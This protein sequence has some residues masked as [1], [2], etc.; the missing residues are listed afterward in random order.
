MAITNVIG[1]QELEFRT[2]IV[3][4]EDCISLTKYYKAS[5]LE[6]AVVTTI[7]TKQT[8]LLEFTRDGLQK[9]NHAE[10]VITV[11]VII[12]NKKAVDGKGFAAIE[13]RS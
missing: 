5:Q 1:E 10:D 12:K 13:Y 7:G 11:L 3:A 2:C 9:I 4:F 6:N 8:F